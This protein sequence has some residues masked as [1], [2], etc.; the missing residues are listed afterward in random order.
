M[1]FSRREMGVRIEADGRL[2]LQETN[3]DTPAHKLVS[4][5]MILGNETAALFGR[6]HS[7]PMIYRSQEAPDVNPEQQGLEIAEG[8][9]RDY[10]QRSFLKRSLTGAVSGSHYGLGLP[11]YVQI[12][13][14]LRR[15][16]DL[17]NQRQLMHYLQTQEALYSAEQLS[18]LHASLETGLD[19]AMLI[20]RERNRYFLLKYLKQEQISRIEAIVIKTDGPKPLAELDRIFMLS[21]FHPLSDMRSPDVARKRR[22][23]R[24]LLRIDSLDPR[25]DSLVLREV[26]E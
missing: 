21:P 14:P 20:Q 17:M 22:G 5:M 6:E 2:S 18:E 4:E 8:P 16:A 23:E 1:Q 9:A 13:S 24:I 15:A 11:A 19:E 7:L 25:A 10:F 3:E 12:T 26:K